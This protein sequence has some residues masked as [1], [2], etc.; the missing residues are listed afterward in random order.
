MKLVTMYDGKITSE[1]DIDWTVFDALSNAEM[2]MMS[3]SD[4]EAIEYTEF[5]NRIELPHVRK[6]QNVHSVKNL[7]E[8][9]EMKKIID[10]N[11][12]LKADLK[13]EMLTLLTANK[14]LVEHLKSACEKLITGERMTKKQ[15]AALEVVDINKLPGGFYFPIN[16]I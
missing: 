5:K 1:K 2:V 10:E 16:E 11:E 7:R 9:I 12:K 6:I 13:K 14:L 4:Y 8:F 3:E 15:Q